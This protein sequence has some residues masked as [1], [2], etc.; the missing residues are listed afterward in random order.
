MRRLSSSPTSRVSQFDVHL[1]PRIPGG[2]RP[3]VRERRNSNP[4]GPRGSLR[5]TT[6]SANLPVDGLTVPC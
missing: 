3:S 5:S 4:L 1:R 2:S 6:E